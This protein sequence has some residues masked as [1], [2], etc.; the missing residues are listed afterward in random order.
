[1]IWF[2]LIASFI[3][4]IVIGMVIQSYRY[5]INDHTFIFPNLPSV[6]EGT[7]IL[8][9]SD[10]HKRRVSKRILNKIR[11][12][13]SIDFVFIGGDLVEKGVEL[14]QV[15]KNINLLTAL[16]PTYFVWGNHDLKYDVAQLTSV[17][18]TEGVQI[19]DNQA[20]I[21]KSEQSQRLWLIGVGDICTKKDQLDLA[22]RDTYRDGGFRILLAHVPTITKK[23]KPKHRIALVLSGHTHGGQISLP[24]IGPITGAVGQLFPKQ[25]VGYYDH[26]YTKLFISSG[27]GTSHFPLRL[28]T[29]P[30]VVVFN[31]Q[32]T[33]KSE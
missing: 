1:M 18:I 17:L 21:L 11:D 33:K 32:R 19:L 15:K 20:V 10:I 2:W 6:F 27:Y 23:I 8:F 25:V 22:L 16:A 24:W 13:Y 28:F 9:I 14:E 31:L 30:E 3:V 29:T 4:F 26:N 7:S 12:N 5:T